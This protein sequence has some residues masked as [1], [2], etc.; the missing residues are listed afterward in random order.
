MSRFTCAL[1]ENRSIY[2]QNKTGDILFSMFPFHIATVEEGKYTNYLL[3]CN[4]CCNDIN[5]LR[6]DKHKLQPYKLRNNK[7]YKEN[8]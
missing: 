5:K 7:Y 3:F 1:C 2:K 4:D 6:T 8:N